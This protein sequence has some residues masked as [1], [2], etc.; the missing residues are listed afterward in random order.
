MFLSKKRFQIVCIVSFLAVLVACPSFA[1]KQKEKLEWSRPRK[2][3]LEV[4]WDTRPARYLRKH[5]ENMEQAPFDGV[6]FKLDK[7]VSFC[8]FFNISFA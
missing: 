5:I 6:I 3:L 2:K 1:E 7:E 8:A 4:G